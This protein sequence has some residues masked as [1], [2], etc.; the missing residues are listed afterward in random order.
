MPGTTFLQ[1]L[2]THERTLDNG[3]TVIVREDHSV[4]VVAVVT[5]VRAGY[6]DEPDQL[7]GISHVL[8][9]MYFKGTVRRGAGEIARETKEAGGYLNAGTIYDRTSYYT[10]LPSESLEQALDIQAD[11]LQHSVIDADELRR[12]LQVII[13]EAKRKLDNPAAVA[14]ETL[15]ETMFDVHRIRRWRI[16]TESMLENF[17]RQHVNDYYRNLYRASNT[18]LVIAGDVDADRAFEL[19][20]TYYGG[21][22]A[23]EPV[24]DGGSDEPARRGFRYRELAG[25]I[26]QSYIEWGWRTPGTLHPD[27]PALD[28]LAIALGQGRASR[29]YRH[30]RDAGAAAAISAFNYTPTTIGVFGIG[31]ELDPPD[32]RSAFER[33]AATLQAVLDHGFTDE[34]TERARNIL[35]ARMIR[36][37]ETVE[38]QANLIADWQALG[39]WRLADDYLDSVLG[40]TSDRLHDVAHH[41]LQPDGLTA[42]LYRP[43]DAEPFATDADALHATLFTGNVTGGTADAQP[44]DG[45]AGGVTDVTPA[46][47]A[48]PRPVSDAGR[49]PGRL[50]PLRVEDDVRRYRSE[51]GAMI[52]IKA[53]PT[54]PL[55]SMALYCRG[56]MLAEDGTS[57]GLTS[58]MA[59]TSVKGT[60]N[61]TGLQL[62]RAIEALGGSVSPGT[63]A[64][65]IDWSTS[66]P[67]RHFEAAAGLLLDAALEPSF[68]AADAERERKIMLSDLEQLRDDMQQYPLRLALSDAFAGHPYGF[69][70]EQLEQSIRGIDLARLHEWHRDRV[71]RGAPHVFIV[72]DV[73][74]PD[75]AAAM[76]A[77]IL[78]AQL[79][80][81]VAAGRTAAGWGGPAQRV[82][83]RDKAQTAIVLAFPGPPRNHADVYAL[84]VLSSAI[85]GLG[86][87]LFEELRSRRSLAYA[88]SASPVSRWLGGAF[89]SY[90]GTA[91]DREDEA[92]EALLQE[93]LRT[94]SEPLPEADIERARRYMVG[95]WQIRQQTHSRQL[96]DLAHALLLGEGLAELRD[97]PDRVRAVDA[98]TIQ[99]AAARWFRQEHLVEA[100]VRGSGGAR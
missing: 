95:A 78:D 29:L 35:E 60:R 73:A 21:M 96:A 83:Q 66:V 69:A 28:V 4:P 57:A 77:G 9:H 59:R 1:R 74:D 71:L 52:V 61:R 12:E 25:D 67:A 72:G 81:P 94:A 32:T 80:E 100:V 65:V 46:R 79:E 26:A 40:V 93:L 24:R 42:L 55:V 99:A 27:T 76:V 37:L 43:R 11:A 15:F 92:R 49:R 10:V 3:L 41:Y 36:R 85:A 51:R 14:Q 86:G 50:E 89:I 16:G 68:E 84:Q 2:P 54:V 97:Y 82:E 17:T 30:V 91:P 47:S 31:A 38:G 19:A 64:D 39:D 20:G 45:A 90:I 62:A 34:E 8:E 56:G 23:G 98:A 6:F 53:R 33:M 75:A 13:Q 88:V 7:V 44:D 22:D 5:H 18:I 87:R 48:P 58:L 63:G 70:I